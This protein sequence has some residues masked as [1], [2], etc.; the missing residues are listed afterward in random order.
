MKSLKDLF[1][2]NTNKNKMHSKFMHGKK[3]C[4]EGITQ[5]IK[6]V[7]IYGKQ[8]NLSYKGDDSFKTLPGAL[9]SIIIVA[10]LLAYSSF[11]SFVLFSKNNP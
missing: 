7:D 1:P 9:S 6:S 11:R 8:I 5:Q 3:N 10:I 4:T 2:P